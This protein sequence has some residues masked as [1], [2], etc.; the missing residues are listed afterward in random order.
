MATAL[1]CT[2]DCSSK[3]AALRA[4]GYD[5]IIR[6]Y[7][8]STWKRLGAPEAQTLSRAGLRLVSVYQDRQNQP[9]DFSLTKGQLAAHNAF[10]YAQSVIFQPEGSA[11]YFSADFDPTADVVTNQIVPFFRGIRETLL[12][13]NGNTMPYRIGI[14]GSGRTCRM[15][16]DANLAELA[17]LAQSTGFADY[18]AFLASGRWNLSQ[19]MPASVA[20]LDCDPDDIN[21]QRPD[22][23]AFMLAQDHFG[24]ALPPTGTDRF[25][26]NATNGLRLRGGPGVN[27]DILKVLPAGATVTVTH[28]DGDWA[29]VDSTGDGRADGYVFASYLKPV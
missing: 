21:P 4:A 1:D 14:Y 11:I 29:Q 19:H 25:V 24:P 12:A 22:C 3:A 9:S 20:G 6:Y 18:Q 23:G 17:W 28:T 16:L 2:H 5:T 10:T 13:A 15:L 7:S 26:V 8:M 27:F